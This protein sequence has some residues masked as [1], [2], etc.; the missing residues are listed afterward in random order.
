MFFPIPFIK[1]S[2]NGMIIDGKGKNNKKENNL[3][4]TMFILDKTLLLFVALTG[5]I[6]GLSVLYMAESSR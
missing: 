6:R 5:F 2:I 1:T 4:T 3:T